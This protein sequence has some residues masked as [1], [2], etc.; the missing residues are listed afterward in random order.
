MIDISELKLMPVSEKQLKEA[1]LTS[2][3][4]AHLDFT[5]EGGI[6]VIF[7]RAG[8]RYIGHVV[9]GFKDLE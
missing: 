9:S 1:Y 4:E 3:Q 7:W 6:V 8:V 2:D 5:D